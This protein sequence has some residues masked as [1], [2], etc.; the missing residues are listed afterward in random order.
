PAPAPEPVKA[1]FEE[2]QGDLYAPAQAVP[3]PAPAPS[4]AAAP[5]PQISRPITRIVDPSVEE[6]DEEPLFSQP[7]FEDRRPSRGGFLSLF[8]SRPRY[9]EPAPQHQPRQ[10]SIS[11]TSAQPVEQSVEEPQ[12]DN[13]E[14]L[15]IPSFL[16]RLAN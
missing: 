7:A 6:V 9:Q 16:R 10:A 14:D 5:E 11:R 1:A 13:Q 8:G 4:V 15:E 2:E 12:T 3:A